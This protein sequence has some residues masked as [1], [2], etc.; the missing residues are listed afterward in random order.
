MQEELPLLLISSTAPENLRLSP[1]LLLKN[2]KS[3]LFMALN[4]TCVYLQE[5][6]KEGAI[7]ESI[8]DGVIFYTAV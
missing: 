3:I 6:K 7:K 4:E 8:F 5:L 1:R 2:L